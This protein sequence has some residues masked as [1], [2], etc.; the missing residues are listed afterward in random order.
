MAKATTALACRT[1]VLRQSVPPCRRRRLFFTITT[2][3]SPWLW[4]HED[5]RAKQKSQRVDCVSPQG[6]NLRRWDGIFPPWPR[7]W[8]LNTGVLNLIGQNRG[9]TGRATQEDETEAPHCPGRPGLRV[10]PVSK[11]LQ[12]RRGREG[13]KAGTL[14]YSSVL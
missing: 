14:G 10:R 13:G 12:R 9:R 2:L 3:S 5:L 4:T 1:G 11:P 6:S 8:P 7:L